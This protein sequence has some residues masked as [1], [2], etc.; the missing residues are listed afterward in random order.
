MKSLNFTDTAPLNQDSEG[1]IHLTGSRVTFDTLLAAYLRGDA[2]EQIQA[3]FPL[4]SLAQIYGAI[5]WYLNHQGEAE[6]YLAERET[7]ADDIRREI[8]SQPEQS[9]FRELLRQR[10]EQLLKS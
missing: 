9:A 2:A 5:A 6:A 3:N 10:R 7:Q 1:T 8:E 4:L